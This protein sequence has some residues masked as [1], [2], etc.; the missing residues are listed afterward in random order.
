MNEIS[1]SES[2]DIIKQVPLVRYEC[3]LEK[4][5][6]SDLFKALNKAISDMEKLEKIEEELEQAHNNSFIFRDAQYILDGI[7]Q[8]VKG[9]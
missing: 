8:I 7:E 9:N 4:G 5:R 3:E 1:R 2:I 6:Q